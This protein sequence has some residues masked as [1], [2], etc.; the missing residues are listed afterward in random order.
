MSRLSLVRPQLA[1]SLLP[2]SAPTRST[3]AALRCRRTPCGPAEA[4]G[5]ISALEQ[6]LREPRYVTPGATGSPIDHRALTLRD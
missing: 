4:A 2:T 3:M 5:R 6:R 1:Q